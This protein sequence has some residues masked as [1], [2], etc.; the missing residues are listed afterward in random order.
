[1]SKN[2]SLALGLF[3]LLP[4]PGSA[5]NQQKPIQVFGGQPDERAS[6]RILYETDKAIGEFAIDYGRPVWKK[7]YEDPAI[8]DKM[9]RGKVW[10]LGKDF[11][12]TLDTSLPLSITGREVSIGYYYLG[13][14][15][16]EDGATWSLVFLDPVEIRSSKL[17]AFE[18]NKAPIAFR[19]P[20]NVEKGSET[21]D[22]LT[23][24]LSHQKQNITS[25]TLR[26]AWG[27]LHLNAPIEVLL[28]H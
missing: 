6:T 3:F 11:W 4:P 8:F 18:I 23:L 28:K 19:V 14:H 2:L 26:I 1:M 20:V 12:T 27:K 21:V 24:L 5:Q 9:T 15:R 16:S 17:D 22:K 13:L 10:R 7:Q 25:V